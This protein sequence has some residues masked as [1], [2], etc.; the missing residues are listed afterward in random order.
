MVF[1]VFMLLITLS[2][3]QVIPSIAFLLIFETGSKKDK[4]IMEMWYIYMMEFYSAIKK[5]EIG[6]EM[7][8]TE[9]YQVE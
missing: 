6:G 9:N 5:D 3:N 4:W 2:D 7:D 1:S 8:G